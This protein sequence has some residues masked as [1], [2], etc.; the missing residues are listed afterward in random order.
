MVATLA[1]TWRSIFTLLVIYG[2]QTGTRTSVAQNSE[3][4]PQFCEDLS[5]IAG[6]TNLWQKEAENHPK[7]GLAFDQPPLLAFEYPAEETPSSLDDDL[8]LHRMRS[9]EC[10]ET[11]TLQGMSET[12]GSGLEAAQVQVPQQVPQDK[13]CPRGFR[14]GAKQGRGVS[15]VRGEGPMDSN[16][17]VQNCS[18]CPMHRSAPAVCSGRIGYGASICSAASRTSAQGISGGQLVSGGEK[19]A[20]K[21]AWYP[22][23]DGPAG[24]TPDAVSRTRAEG[25]ESHCSESPVSWPSQQAQQA[26]D[27]SGSR[28]QKSPGHGPGVAALHVQDDGEGQAARSAVSAGQSRPFRGLQFQVAGVGDGESRGFAGLAEPRQ[29]TLD[30]ALGRN[31]PRSARSNGGASEC[32]QRRGTCQSSG[33]S[34]RPL[35]EGGGGRCRDGGG[36]QNPQQESVT[37]G[38]E[39]LQISDIALWCGKDPSEEQGSQSR[40][41]NEGPQGEQGVDANQDMRRREMAQQD[42]GVVS[43]SAQSSQHRAPPNFSQFF[44][45]LRLDDVYSWHVSGQSDFVHC[46]MPLH[47]ISGQLFSPLSSLLHSQYSQCERGQECGQIH[48]SKFVEQGRG[49]PLFHVLHGVGEQHADF[50]HTQEFC[51]HV[52]SGPYDPFG[53]LLQEASPQVS[54]HPMCCSTEPYVA[55][56]DMAQSVGGQVWDQN[57]SRTPRKACWSPQQVKSLVGRRNCE[58]SVHFDSP[59]SWTSPH[60]K[61]F[62]ACNEGNSDLLE[63]THDFTQK[64]HLSSAGDVADADL[65]TCDQDNLDL[66]DGT[67]VYVTRADGCRGVYLHMSD[68]PSQTCSPGCA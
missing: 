63:A 67:Q 33:R 29:P 8:V 57:F 28:G 54:S 60:T 58:M 44:D 42:S 34:H 50:L 43:L 9:P 45:E 1:T 11:G 32:L 64:P 46:P 53:P 35:G 7:V 23:G 56:A 6:S 22:R 20:R 38:A 19:V 66:I 15:V 55:P 47:D 4:L 36:C 10:A 14:E 40:W 27:P 21:S 62:Q 26:Q 31:D 12:L 41:E 48:G 3:A 24:S 18:I 52:N 61:L 65:V 16:H 39:A 25:A 13:V 37:P 49:L 5:E 51:S 17:S 2:C 59:C 30:A 68:L